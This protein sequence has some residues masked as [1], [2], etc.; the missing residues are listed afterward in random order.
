LYNSSLRL[1][2]RSII[3]LKQNKTYYNDYEITAVFYCKGSTRHH[4]GKDALESF[5][6]NIYILHPLIDPD[7]K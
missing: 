4:Y 5:L 2:N 3:L 1:C 6:S 7:I